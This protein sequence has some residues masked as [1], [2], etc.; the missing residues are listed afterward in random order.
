M[1]ETSAAAWVHADFRG[2]KGREQ[3]TKAGQKESTLLLRRSTK[4]VVGGDAPRTEASVHR[5]WPFFLFL[6]FLAT[7]GS[8]FRNCFFLLQTPL[9]AREKP[10]VVGTHDSTCQRTHPGSA[11]YARRFVSSEL[12]C[13]VANAVAMVRRRQVSPRSA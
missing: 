12:R 1:T 10:S 3:E 2:D 9:H 6:F 13:D 11:G 4:V 7:A 8:C 5:L